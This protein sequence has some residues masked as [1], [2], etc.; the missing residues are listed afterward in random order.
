MKRIDDIIF[1]KFVCNT[2]SQSDMVEVE[3]QLLKAKKYLHLFMLLSLI[4]K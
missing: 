1:N 4:M 2:L 3:K